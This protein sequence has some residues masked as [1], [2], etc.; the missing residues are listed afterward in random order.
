MNANDE[1]QDWLRQYAEGNADAEV[2]RQLGEAL[3]TDAELRVLLVD[4][5]NVDLAL[6]SSAVLGE[7]RPV[8]LPHRR[9]P[10]PPLLRLAACVALLATAAWW[11][12]RPEV[13][14]LRAVSDEPAALAR[15]EWRGRTVELRQGLLELR[16]RRADATVV[17]E[18]PAAFR[19]EDAKTLRLE[20]G[21][22]TA[23]VRDGRHG[24]RVLTPHTDVLDLG[25]R[26]AVDINSEGR[27]EVHVFEGKMEAGRAGE[28]K[29]DLLT[30]NQALRIAASAQPVSREMRSGSFVQPEEMK[31]LSAGLRSGQARRAAE[32]EAGLRRDGALIGY[33]AFEIG[34]DESAVTM[35]GAAEVQ[36]RFPGRRALEFVDVDDHARLN[37][38]ATTRHL[39]L[40]TW[41]RL[42]RV[43]ENI[44]SLYHTD[45]WDTDG[46][47]H[48]MILN[49]GQMRFAI[50]GAPHIEWSGS[51][52]SWPQSTGAVTGEPGRW[53][54]LAAVYDADS[55]TVS[56]YRDGR[57][58]SSVD[59]KTGLPAV[60]GPAQL[61]NWNIKDGFGTEHRRLS[62]RMDE[63]VALSRCLSA[64][65]IRQ[66]HGAGTPYR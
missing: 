51:K 60:L 33:I 20:R 59:M 24:L 40:M 38:N 21:R 4:Y 57:I 8:K 26:F 27:S 43:P 30:T 46:Q 44:S 23:H 47:V 32:A 61:G 65:E 11:F 55:A 45:G 50:K 5:L 52:A 48:W 42:D 19:I 25:T 14:L 66:A 37:L 22:V 10:L 64:E 15:G 39:T 6:S 7:A 63:L 9:F 16:F 2:T 41:V 62:G 36:G 29:R 1:W 58:D 49:N 54:H 35:Q 34:A 56:F 31:A 18:A 17:I 12:L 53:M 28:L 3:R 13:S